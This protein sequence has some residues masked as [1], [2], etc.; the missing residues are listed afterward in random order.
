M[1]EAPA[2]PAF[3]ESIIQ[4]VA[5]VQQQL[6][7]GHQVINRSDIKEFFSSTIKQ[8]IQVIDYSPENYE[9]TDRKSVV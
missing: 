3:D 8:P 9:G 2:F 1:K 7:N 5:F 6:E 4:R